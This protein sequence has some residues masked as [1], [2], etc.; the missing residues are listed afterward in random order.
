MRRKSTVAGLHL[1]RGIRMEYKWNLNGIQMESEWNPKKSKR[2]TRIRLV[3]KQVIVSNRTEYML[4]SDLDDIG[5]S[6]PCKAPSTPVAS[7]PTPLRVEFTV[8]CIS[9][10]PPLKFVA[11]QERESG[12]CYLRTALGPAID[13][14]AGDAHLAHYRQPHCC[15]RRV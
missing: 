10:Y 7:P 9:Q 11:G 13:Q 15:Y 14:S 1:H 2:S 4:V 12:L 3:C 8:G 5:G 6:V